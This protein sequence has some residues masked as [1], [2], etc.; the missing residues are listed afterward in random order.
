MPKSL[1][2]PAANIHRC[3]LIAMFKNHR[4]QIIINQCKT[5]AADYYYCYYFAHF[6]LFFEFRILSKSHKI[7]VISLGA[8]YFYTT[9][10]RNK[11]V[12]VKGKKLSFLLKYSTTR[13]S[14]KSNRK[15]LCH[16]LCP[17]K[18]KCSLYSQLHTPL[19]TNLW[20]CVCLHKSGSTGYI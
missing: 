20:L 9:I 8:L 12:V 16:L 1:L 18:L 11:N 10:Y 3:L 6:E 15:L 19:D 4:I 7:C 13:Q 17:L 2:T 5:V 14:L